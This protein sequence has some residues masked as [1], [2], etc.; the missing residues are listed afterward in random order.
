MKVNS[1]NPAISMPK[2]M[3][4]KRTNVDV[5]VVRK[6]GKYNVISMSEYLKTPL[7]FKGRNKEQAIFYG[8]EAAPYSKKGGVATVMKDYGLLL[9]QKDEVVVTPYYGADVNKKEGTVTPKKN[10]NGDYV[11]KI[12]KEK[13]EVLDLVAEK[14]MQWGEKENNKIMLFRLRNEESRVH[15]FVFDET[16]SQMKAPY[17]DTFLYQTGGKSATNAW[18]G[19]T[20]AKNSKAFVEL[21]PDLIA[22][23][24][25]FDPATVVCSDS[26]TA[27]T[28]EYMMQ[29]ASKDD[30]YDEI[31]T[32]HV[33]HNLGPGYC[34]ETSKRNMFV[35]LG[36]TPAQIKMIEDDPIYKQGLLGD[37]Y[38]KPFVEETLD[39]TGTANA[40]KIALQHA[41]DGFVKSFSVVAED[42][43]ES[44]A[45]N[46]QATYTIHNIAK[47][48]YAKGIFNGILNPLEDPS[49]DPT[50][51]LP[52]AR[53]NED[54][55]DTDGKT[56]Y[57][58]FE[59]YPQNA[60]YEQMKEVK[61]SNKQKLFERFS[62]KDITIIA[63]SRGEKAEK[64]EINPEAKGIYDGPAIKPELID[65]IKQ[66]KG[67]EVPLFVSWGR[68][69]TQ[70]GFDIVLDSFKNFAKTPE[71]KNAV[72]ILGAERNASAESKQ[73]ENRLQ[74]IFKDPD[75]QGR[76]VHID[77]WAPGYALASAADAA[78]F[79]SRFEPCGLTDIEAMKYY[80]TPIVTNTQGFK[81]KNF[82]PRN[83]KE[84]KFA[85]SYKTQHEFDLTKKQV[86]PIIEAYVTK[87]NKAKAKVKKEFPIFWEVEN[88]KR[89]YNETV[90]EKFAEAYT[91]YIVAKEKELKENS[92]D[93]KLP[94]NWNDWD[95]L[96]KNYEFKY[97]GFARDLKDAILAAETTAAIK[98]CANESEET[99]RLMFENKKNLK[100]GWRNNQTLHPATNKSSYELYRDLHMLPDYSKP[101]AD[102]IMAKD[103]SFIANTIKSRQ[104]NDLKE[105]IGAYVAGALTGLGVVFFN[106][107]GNSEVP[108]IEAKFKGQISE[109][110]NKLQENEAKFKEQLANREND[111]NALLKETTEQLNNKIADLIKSN[112]KNM[113]IAG[114]ASAVVAAI[115]TF[116]ATKAYINKKMQKQ[117]VATAP[118][119]KKEAQP[120]PTP[121]EAK[122]A[123]ATVEKKE[124]QPVSTPIKPST[125][126]LA[127]KSNGVFASF[128]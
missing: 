85:T 18:N 109:L 7:S 116:F 62:A 15:Y 70:K 122:P 73:V 20:Y 114:G 68:L 64:T 48:L 97:R 95:N 51:P 30:K 36:A 49:I 125:T 32:T 31:K 13:F 44:I 61:N 83:E 11:I 123:V 41:K 29:K 52:N 78:L 42:Y 9:D 76:V 101:Q 14:T 90:F 82:D 92:A 75:L 43:A 19:D 50:K 58:A 102:K 5:P 107:A 39:E 22:D 6:V 28:H 8:A 65:L 103:D 119:E 88:G 81:Q 53:Y 72:L 79:T 87:N 33:G 128:N 57:P 27:Y 67:D 3:A 12:G 2:S 45:T 37:D 113:I 26:Q 108:E 16:T 25:D 86:D 93:G 69:D 54:C 121:V 117:L 23:K 56:T 99:K 21:L 100:T 55:V 59:V 38:F 118:I 47:E 74:E 105:R 4:I 110:Q 60:T 46:P 120:V 124:Q 77:G 127:T 10:E 104:H 66:G 91:E 98:A 106:K 1:V 126:K 84:A 35:N 96:S 71:G 17:E 63:G 80:C 24:K 111:F 34:G 115:I 94:E 40:A 112:K 89:K